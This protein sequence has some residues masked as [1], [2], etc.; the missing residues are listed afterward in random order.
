M[1]LVPLLRRWDL[2][3]EAK[4]DDIVL[5]AIGKGTVERIYSC[6]DLLQD[7]TRWLSPNE[8]SFKQNVVMVSSR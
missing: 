3:S 1:S 7:F 8:F 2:A 5:G 6:L 4:R